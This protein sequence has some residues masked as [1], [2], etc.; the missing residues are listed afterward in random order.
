MIRQAG[1]PARD[2]IKAI[3]AEALVHQPTE[4][5]LAILEPA[6]VWCARVLQWPELLASEGFQAL[7]MLQLV[8]RPDG[9]EILTTRSPLRIDGARPPLSRAAPTIGEQSDAIRRELGL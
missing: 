9:V 4:H 6:D 3:I 2:E 8:T 7:D 1:L 5:W